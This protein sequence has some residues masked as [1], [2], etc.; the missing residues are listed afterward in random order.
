VAIATGTVEVPSTRR[1]FRVSDGPVNL[2]CPALQRCV[3]EQRPRVGALAAVSVFHSRLPVS[4]GEP[5]RRWAGDRGA[6]PSSRPVKVALP[7]VQPYVGAHQSWND[8]CGYAKFPAPLTETARYMR[9]VLWAAAR[10]LT[11]AGTRAHGA[12]LSTLSRHGQAAGGHLAL[13]RWGE[14]RDG[15]LSHAHG[16]YFSTSEGCR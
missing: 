7:K 1:V 2:R 3:L 13:A 15:G 6:E 12:R 10:G 11:H 4:S 5:L 8:S 9:T 14:A 16:W